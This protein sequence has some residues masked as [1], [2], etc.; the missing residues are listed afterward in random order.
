MRRYCVQGIL[1]L[2][3]VFAQHESLTHQISHAAQQAS[4]QD[5]SRDTSK[6]CDKCLALSHLGDSLPASSPVIVAANAAWQTPP[7][8]D[9]IERLSPFFAY[10][11][12]A[13]PTT[14]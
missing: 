1:L 7:T 8:R 6:P 3:L 4:Q 5:P 14:L 11:S 9:V 10:R 12:R 13:P 2:L